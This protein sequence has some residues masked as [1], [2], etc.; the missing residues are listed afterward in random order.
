MHILEKVV[1]ME[2]VDKEGI[3][4]RIGLLENISVQSRAAL[5][6]ICLPKRVEKKQPLFFEGEKGFALYI[7]VTG[8]IQLYKRGPEARRIVIK[9]VKPGEMFGEVVLFEQEHYPV[10]A[11]TV[12]ESM[13]FVVPKH[14][15]SC[16]LAQELFRNDFMANLMKKMR[17][18]TEQIR[19]LSAYDVEDRLLLFLQEHYGR[20]EQLQPKLSKKDVAAGI[21]TT[22]ETLSRLLLRMHQEK[23]VVWEGGRID[24]PLQVWQQ[25]DE[26]ME[27][28]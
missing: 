2:F 27:E 20:H 12:K 23:G 6:E 16:L 15:F 3:L 8:S 9:V 14:Q 17:Y 4:A 26:H 25:L 21:G 10:S 24:V 7:L 22:P 1:K 5:A 19:Y 28:H 11:E 13:V 18:L